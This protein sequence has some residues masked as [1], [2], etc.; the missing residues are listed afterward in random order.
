MIQGACTFQRVEGS[1]RKWFWIAALGVV[2]LV[3]SASLAISI[4]VSFAVKGEAE[5]PS[6]FRQFL[7]IAVN[8]ACPP[9]AVPSFC[10]NV[11]FTITILPQK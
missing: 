4:G 8:V 10:F 11:S 2:L 1:R 5:A 3:T 7:T 9:D 6:R